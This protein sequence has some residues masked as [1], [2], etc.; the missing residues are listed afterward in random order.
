[1]RLALLRM[2]QTAGPALVNHTGLVLCAALIV[3][4]LVWH[5]EMAIAAAGNA[6]DVHEGAPK[7]GVAVQHRLGVRLRFL[8]LQQEQPRA[9]R[10]ERYLR[11]RMPRAVV[12]ERREHPVD[13]VQLQHGRAIDEVC[14]HN[15]TCSGE[16]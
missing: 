15:C 5:L 2:L 13:W 3:V 8:P 6:G 10:V 14:P 7:L 12:A 16:Y 4:C 11:A 9:T 1:M